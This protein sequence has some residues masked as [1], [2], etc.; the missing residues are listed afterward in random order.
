MSQRPTDVG[1]GFTVNDR[2]LFL[3]KSILLPPR[4]EA[5]RK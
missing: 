4:Q 2:I 1:T 3:K 5:V